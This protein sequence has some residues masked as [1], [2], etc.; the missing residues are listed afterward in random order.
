MAVRGVGI[1][2]DVGQ[3]ADLRHRILD[4]LDRA[5]DQVVGVERLARIVGAQARRRVGE[6]RDAGNAEVARLPRPVR[7]AG[8]PTSATRRAASRSAPPAP[9]PSQMNSGQM[10]SLGCS[11]C[12]GEHGA[13][14]GRGAAAAHA[15]R[16]EGG[17]LP[18]AR[19]SSARWTD[20]K[21]AVPAALSGH[22]R[23]ASETGDP[24]RQCHEPQRRRR[25]RRGTRQAGRCRASS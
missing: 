24:D 19:G 22:G 16:R 1:E 5:A 18:C 7:R 3:H 14:P 21:K 10:R 13:D 9:R 17:V 8:R 20:G 6:Q 11:R 25:I 4:R 23:C 12:L 15:Q 2:R